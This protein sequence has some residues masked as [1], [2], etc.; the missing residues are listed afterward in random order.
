MMSG[1]GQKGGEWYY[2]ENYDD[3][4]DF[5]FYR[6]KQGVTV[7]E[8]DMYVLRPGRYSAAPATVQSLYAPEFLG[9]SKGCLFTPEP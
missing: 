9:R 8:F 1:F 4:S 7:L 5:Y 6:L 3:R 2:V